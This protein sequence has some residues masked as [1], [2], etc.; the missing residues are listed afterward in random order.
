[1][2]DVNQAAQALQQTISSLGN[3]FGGLTKEI[4]DF[5]NGLQQQ[6]KSDLEAYEEYLTDRI[7]G[8]DAIAKKRRKTLTDIWQS[9]QAY[10][11]KRE[12]LKNAARKDLLEFGQAMKRRKELEKR[13]ENAEADLPAW[14]K[15]DLEAQIKT[16]KDVEIKQR[17]IYQERQLSEKQANAAIQT[18]NERRMEAEDTMSKGLG[19]AR[20][21]EFLKDSLKKMFS[22]ALSGDLFKRGMKEMFST[23][24]TEITSGISIP[25]AEYFKVGFKLGL[26]PEEYAKLTRANRDTVLAAGGLRGH[27]DTLSDMSQKYAT[28]IGDLTERTQFAQ[29]Q[30]RLFGESGIRPTAKNMAAL[31]P[32]MQRLLKVTELA[33]AELNSALKDI[34]EDEG[35]QFQLRAANNEQERMMI[36][37]GIAGRIAENR[38]LGMS[39]KQA[40]EASKALNKLTAQ[41]PLERFKQA[42]K[43]RAFG[44]AMGVGGTDDAARILM[45]GSRASEA[46]RRQLQGVLSNMSNTLSES[47]QGSIGGEIFASTLADKLDLQSLIGSG[48]PFN[49]RQ[50]EG[51]KYNEDAVKNLGQID[52]RVA[53]SVDFLQRILMAI[54][55][56][57]LLMAIAGGVGLLANFFLG[58]IFTKVFGKLLGRVLGKIPGLGKIFGAG[59]EAALSGSSKAIGAVEKAGAKGV[60]EVATKI[61]GKAVAKSLVKKIPLI[62]L[63]AGLGFAGMRAYEGDWL[64]AGMEVAS[65]AMSTLPGLG[66][67]GSVAMDV[68]LAARDVARAGGE[69]GGGGG[70]GTETSTDK[71]EQMTDDIDE[72]LEHVKESNKT[73][74]EM[75]KVLQDSNDIQKQ[76]L[77]AFA[78]SDEKEQ[79]A[80]N[81][82]E[83]LGNIRNMSQ[84]YK[85]IAGETF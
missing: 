17:K 12:E 76:L 77:I 5:S 27:L 41:G 50:A 56:N 26:S 67:A 9:E 37:K 54:E 64:G 36:L 34:A 44:A 51:L 24:K 65:G 42:A 33:P 82:G 66:T 20:V 61:G 1:M 10:F 22:T 13:L 84:R 85:N 38:A 73:L 3:S 4:A 58:G 45:K 72:S 29:D 47:A 69:S 18:M 14:R 79:K 8:E 57:P 49:T 75:L 16:A 52:A 68:G 74:V 40:I 55:K 31:A 2:A 35:T 46:E 53:K 70:T 59:G 7:S 63:L 25:L 62:G 21:G 30:M 78:M 43:L 80:M 71:Q 6:Q 23:V 11:K 28:T 15:K 32:E 48:S 83:R 39:T 60:G 81:T 19:K